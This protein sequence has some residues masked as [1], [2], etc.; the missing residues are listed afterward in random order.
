M[1]LSVTSSNFRD[2]VVYPSGCFALGTSLT[3]LRLLEYQENGIGN[4]LRRQFESK[5]ILKTAYNVL[6]VVDADVAAVG[7][8][9]PFFR[10]WLE[11]ET[12]GD[13]WWSPVDFGRDLRNVPPASLVGGWYDLFLPSQVDDFVALRSAGRSVRLTIG[14]WSHS[15]PGAVAASLRDGLEWFDGHF[16]G[17]PDDRP[18]NVVRIFVMGVRRWV[19]FPDWPPPTVDHTWFL[20]DRGTLQ[21]SGPGSG[22]PDHFHYDPD[23]PTP[24]V[25][26]ASLNAGDSGPKDQRPREQ[27]S[28][29]LTFTSEVLTGDLTVVGPLS[30]D[31]CVRSTSDHCDFFV[32]LCDVSPKGTSTNL[33]DGLVRLTPEAMTKAA[34]GSLLVHISMWP[35]ANAFRRNH[36][37][38]LQISSGAHPLFLR[39]SGTGDPLVVSSHQRDADQDIFHDP[40]HPSCLNLPV[41]R[42]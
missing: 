42:L 23:D 36:R 25:G 20:G 27:R 6:P 11:H 29:V 1:A 9:I 5:R 17:G 31:L 37:I 24:A 33:S 8:P 14:P 39:N 26:G 7:R 22:P 41:M 28:D 15:S 30:A 2:A 35:T 3:W 16:N 13:P 21:T 38:R 40:D 32:R 10:D 4:A 34:D 18:R 12:P 19:E